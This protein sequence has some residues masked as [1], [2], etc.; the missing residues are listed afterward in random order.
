VPGVVQVQALALLNTIIYILPLFPEVPQTIIT[1]T[2]WL[3]K[4]NLNEDVWDEK[5]KHGCLYFYIE[6]LV[7]C[8]VEVGLLFIIIFF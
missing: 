8:L 1:P 6:E 7:K 2:P 3:K 4:E 5:C